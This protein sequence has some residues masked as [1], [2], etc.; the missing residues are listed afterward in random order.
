MVGPLHPIAERDL[1]SVIHER[2]EDLR[3]SGT[4]ARL[5]AEAR[6]RLEGYARQPRG[7]VLPR[8]LVGQVRHHD[9]SVTV[10]YAIRDHRGTI[11]HPAGTTVNPLARMRLSS[12]LLLFDGDDAEQVDW[13]RA[14]H[15]S[16]PA[17][18]KPILTRG[19]P[20]ALIEAWG[21]WVY[22]DQRGQLVER[23]QIEALPAI[24]SQ[25]GTRLRIEEIALEPGERR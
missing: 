5:E 11:L 16:E 1:L 25:D 21:T 10:P 24:V 6:Q 13:A 8:A 3:D 23:F 22:F 17:R 19:S 9:P 14:I 2:L 4:L 18:S 12:Q 20:V 15:R 7:R